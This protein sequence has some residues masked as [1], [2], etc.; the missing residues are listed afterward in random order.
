MTDDIFCFVAKVTSVNWFRISNSMLLYTVVVLFVTTITIV[1]HAEDTDGVPNWIH[2]LSEWFYDG[3]ISPKEYEDAISYIIE[4]DIIKPTA[5][6]NL[7]RNIE[8]MTSY[9]YILSGS[10]DT[11]PDPSPVYNHLG[12]GYSTDNHLI[13]L[14]S[15]S[16]QEGAPLCHS[17]ENRVKLYREGKMD[18]SQI[19]TLLTERSLPDRSIWSGETVEWDFVL[20]ADGL[21]VPPITVTDTNGTTTNVGIGTS[22]NRH[23]LE[24]ARLHTF[25]T[26]GTYTWHMP[27]HPH[28]RGTVTVFTSP[29]DDTNATRGSATAPAPPAV[30]RTPADPPHPVYENHGR[31]WSTDNHVML[32]YSP[33]SGD[34][35]HDDSGVCLNYKVRSYYEHGEERYKILD[36]IIEKKWPDRSVYTGETVE[37]DFASSL[38]GI[39]VPPIIVTGADG[40]ATDVE[41]GTSDNRG[42]EIARRHTFDT[43]GTYTWHMPDHPHVRGTVTVFPNS[44]GESIESNDADAPAHVTTGN[45]TSSVAPPPTSGS[46]SAQQPQQQPPPS[47]PSQNKQ[48]PQPQHETGTQGQTASV[49][50]AT[51]P[52]TATVT[53]PPPAQSAPKPTQDEA[54]F[55]FHWEIDRDSI[56][57][58][59]RSSNVN[60]PLEVEFLNGAVTVPDH[61]FALIL[62]HDYGIL[63]S[64]E[65]M[66]WS[67]VQAFALVETLRKIP[68]TVRD[69]YSTQNLALSKWILHSDH[70]IDDIKITPKDSQNIVT[71]SVDAFDNASP[72]VAEIDGKQG[73]YFSQR[74]HHAL[75]LYVTDYGRDYGAVEKI[76]NERYGVSTRIDDYVSL[77]RH[78]TG[79]SASDFQEFY[80]AELV[81]IINIFEEMPTGFHSIPGLD[82]IVRRADGT[83]NPLHSSAPAIAWTQSGYIEFVETA[84]TSNDRDVHRLIIHE[85]AHFMWH[86]L[87]SESLRQDW[88]NLGGWYQSG[89]VWHTTQ[90]T[91]FVS[92]Y[93]HLKNPDEDMAESISSFVIDPDKLKS[94]ANAKYEFIRDRIMQ[95][96]YYIS[97]IRDDLTFD[98]Y[99]L[100]PDYVYPG[101]IVSVDVAVSGEPR[102]DKTLTVQIS[103]NADDAF[104]GAKRAYMRIFSEIGTFVDMYLYPVE[105]SSGSI[106]RG[107]I[108][109]DRSVYHGYWYVNQITVTDMQGNQR[110]EGQNDFGWM[111]Y[112]QSPSSD[113]VPPEYVTRTLELEL[114]Q[115]SER[116]QRHVQILAVSWEVSEDRY[117]DTCLARIDHESA[118]T[119]STDSHGIFDAGTNLCTAEFVITEYH[120]SGNYLVT[121]LVTEDIAGNSAYVTKSDLTGNS[122]HIK[123]ANQDVTPPYLDINNI[124]IRAEPTNPEMPNGET[125]VEITYHASDDKSGLDMV[126]YVLVDPQGLEHFEYHYHDNF[127][128]VFFE[129]EPSILAEY[130]IVTVLPEGSPPGKWGLAE[131]TLADKATNKKSHQFTE[132]IHFEVNE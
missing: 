57:G 130:E 101:K 13:F 24:I 104:E 116:Y 115:D 35:G 99:N 37:W 89:G 119:Y 126:N 23:N 88:I 60:K 4:H 47:P 77:T 27:D 28:V 1:A 114:R 46:Q 121:M 110:F 52:K 53:A 107:E 84:F 12:R 111:M 125:I 42:Q 124:R 59:T 105:G 43:T 58:Y 94:R 40:T 92:S 68:Q 10:T 113:S 129:G 71:V 76:L 81:K 66:E 102:N 106:L 49:P 86:W 25:D 18:D 103:L 54:E 79:E 90:T 21:I 20:Y 85:K 34:C 16:C 131:M 8:N 96:D 122:I 7:P 3:L 19:K 83:V 17:S 64:N 14:W 80:P 117:M 132:I 72:K 29:G 15:D 74:L 6:E 33:R 123:T 55:T 22:D 32:L 44:Q 82:S 67:N 61:S 26:T 31:G 41:I 50:T 73:R 75:V 11:P 98:V 5:I 69:S 9:E 95:G 45:D 100:Y 39:I 109:L 48:Q 93:A 65:G 112:V 38:G 36:L 108:T 87:F 63:L 56:S 62:Q 51:G 78:T 2:T 118:E 120:V 128:T 127:Y 91:E 70:I 30:E 97:K